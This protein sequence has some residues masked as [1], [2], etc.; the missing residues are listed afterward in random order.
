[1][2]IVFESELMQN[3][4]QAE[5][6]SPNLS[7]EALQTGDACSLFFSI[8]TDGVFYVTQE[9]QGSAT[10][11]NKVDLSSA[12]SQQYGGA[13]VTAKTFDVS[14]NLTTG[15]IDLALAI[16]VSGSD[17]LYLSQGNSNTSAAFASGV[18]WT[19]IPF[20]DA[21]NPMP[22]LSICDVYVLQTPSGEYFVVDILKQPGSP[23]NFVY[24][25][26]ISPAGTTK[27]NGNDLSANLTAG[28][29]QSCLGQRTGD[30]VAGIYTFGDILG[31]EELFFTPLFNP[32]DPSQA[33]SPSFL[34]VPAGATA[35]ASATGLTGTSNLFVAGAGVLYVFA[36]GNQ[37]TN[38]T[39]AAIV[40]SDLI[41]G[42][43]NLLASTGSANT[44]VWG[45]NQAGD[46][47]YVQCPAG[48]EASATA[49]STPVPIL[50]GV[51][52][53]AFFLDAQAG[54]SVLFAQTSGEEL[55]ELYQDPIT[56]QWLQH[57]I[58][59]PSTDIKDVIAYNTFTTQITITDDYNT[60]AG[61]T[62]A[63]VSSTS[64]VT[65]YI[66]DVYQVLSPTVPLQVTADPTGVLTIVQATETL[67]TICFHLALSTGE[68]ADI[69]P[70]TDLVTTLSTIQ[71][72]DQLGQVSVTNA[73]G[74]TQLLL[75]STV[76][77]DQRN[78]TAA[79]LQQ[80]V[81]I[82][83]TLPQDGTVKTA[84]SPSAALAASSRKPIPQVWGVSFAA[85]GWT[86]YEGDDA[87]AQF[88]R[89][90]TAAAGPVGDIGSDIEVAA[91]DMFKWLE[92]A[93]NDVQNFFVKAAGDIY[94]FCITIGEDTYS[95]ALD[96]INTVVHAAEFVFNKIGIFFDDLIKW[97][98]FIF[99]WGD[100]LRTHQVIKNVFKL[101][102][103][104]AVAGIA[105]AK[106]DIENFFNG[107]ETKVNNWAGIPDSGS[108]IGTYQTTS[109][110]P[111]GQNSPQSSWAL[112]H[113]KSNITSATTPYTSPNP[114]LSPFTAIFDDLVGL[115][116]Q[117]GDAFNTA[118]T[119]I[120]TQIIEASA[121]LTPG[122]LGQ[123]LVAILMDLLLTT[124]EN[125][126]VTSLDILSQL[127]SGLLD[128]LD[129]P[130]NIPVL[131]KVYFDLTNDTL[132][133][134]DLVCLIV[135]IPTTIMYKL[136]QQTAPFP[137]NA[138]TSAIIAATNYATLQQV[139][140]APPAAALTAAAAPVAPLPLKV[141]SV[142]FNMAAPFAAG[143]LV[144]VGSLKRKVPAG[145]VPTGLNL[146]G[147]ALYLPYIGPDISF[148]LT[149]SYKAWYTIMNDV[150]TAVSIVKT[151]ID[152]LKP[153]AASSLWSNQISPSLE[154]AI[155]ITW[156]VPALAGIILN[157]S[158]QPSD[159]L[160][161][162]SD[163]FFDVGGAITPA[164]LTANW[165]EL[166]PVDQQIAADGFFVGSMAACLLYGVFCFAN[167]VVLI[168]QPATSQSAAT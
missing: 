124:A 165:P 128:L 84:I 114:D 156:L 14:Q 140:N 21:A 20:D 135:A 152:T 137:D 34:T 160:G 8:G 126:V 78:A 138:T 69:N 147:A 16:T 132:S 17:Y 85:G 159:W 67:A 115:L 80:F 77:A 45:L 150:V 28:S 109:A 88:K 82:A 64:P 59:L 39:A 134:L 146:A 99:E 46:L 120:K 36:P 96:C 25:Y 95:F 98:G 15:N 41:A 13:S 168:K 23:L 141:I 154:S 61:N 75:P 55:I 79:S 119:Q 50:S 81:S 62:A 158:P 121:T 22:V 91:G 66:N 162:V 12:L 108:T 151:F 56:T 93:Y 37:N 130:Y 5:V 133:T 30:Y 145:V 18:T 63:A 76:T 90:L 155:N 148:G 49:W 52:Q 73:D 3:N 54:N 58:L 110:M 72:G 27:W 142:I 125:I 19:L 2:K 139:V 164:T 4:K 70:M 7:F 149:T 38:D 131:S 97:L 31:T 89:P 157:T 47:F 43:T 65:V 48:S 113:T 112:H 6:M 153:L 33:P 105:T 57:D 123:K 94:N 111:P 86:Y 24:R 101:Y 136:V 60:P 9:V 161:F 74:S 106:T 104:N 116:D 143:G 53:I 118:F 40:T 32:F 166:D 144:V 163:G 44:T 87:A 122:E 51:E 129:A 35:I 11:W 68:S 127:V 1:M 117:E 102:A 42:V 100:I 26:Y 92:T 71:T 103:N 107:L 167:S 83:A 10:G 29:V